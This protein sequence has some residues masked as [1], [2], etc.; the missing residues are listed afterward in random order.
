MM[1]KK[2]ERRDRNHRKKKEEN[3][4]EL[5]FPKLIAT[6]IDDFVDQ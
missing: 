6:L 2:E 1:E 4:I 5:S 3:Q